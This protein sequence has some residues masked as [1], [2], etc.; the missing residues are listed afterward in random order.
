MTYPVNSPLTEDPFDWYGLSPS[1]PILFTGAYQTRQVG[2]GDS[3]TLGAPGN[4]AGALVS[5]AVPAKMTSAINK[6]ATRAV[7]LYKVTAE[8]I[9]EFA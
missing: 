9:E 8:D 3:L 1:L 6:S 7:A 4:I 5:T 2:V